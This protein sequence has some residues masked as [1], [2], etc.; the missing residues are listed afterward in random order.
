MKRRKYVNTAR[1]K[2]M[3]EEKPIGLIMQMMNIELDEELF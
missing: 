1:I 3:V 2:K